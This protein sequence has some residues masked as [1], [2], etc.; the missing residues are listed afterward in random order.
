[1]TLLHIVT[2]GDDAASAQYGARQIDAHAWAR[3]LAA[4]LELG[5][6]AASMLLGGFVQSL[7]VLLA[8]APPALR[9]RLVLH[10]ADLV[11][12]EGSAGAEDTALWRVPLSALSDASTKRL[13]PLALMEWSLG[14]HRATTALRGN[15]TPYAKAVAVF[16]SA[17]IAYRGLTP[18]HRLLMLPPPPPHQ[19]RHLQRHAQHRLRANNRDELPMTH[20]SHATSEL[21]HYQELL[22][23][24]EARQYEPLQL[25]PQH[26]LH[27]DR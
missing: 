25:R 3:W 20:L 24:H 17:A 2:L 8:A 23:Q 27:P 15:G 12:V 9:A 10:L 26:Q 4:A 14:D 6:G 18:E 5:A 19:R 7:L 13:G 21:L 11:R 1:M 16:K 22:Y